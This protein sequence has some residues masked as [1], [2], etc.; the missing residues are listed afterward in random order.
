[1]AKKI[2]VTEDMIEKDIQINNNDNKKK[3]HFKIYVV[4]Y[5]VLSVFAIIFFGLFYRK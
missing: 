5:C 3:D 1:M 2:K 4:G